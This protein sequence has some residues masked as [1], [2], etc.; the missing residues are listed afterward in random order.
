MNESTFQQMIT[1]YFDYDNT[2]NIYQL[3]PNISDANYF[4]RLPL[5]YKIYLRNPEQLSTF[6]EKLLGALPHISDPNILVYKGANVFTLI[7]FAT[8]HIIKI[9]KIITKMNNQKV[10]VNAYLKF[11]TG[12]QKYIQ[13]DCNQ[14]VLGFASPFTYILFISC[15]TSTQATTVYNE[16][17]QIIL[18][19]P[20]DKNRINVL[21]DV[22][23]PLLADV[24]TDIYNED[25][26]QVDGD[27]FVLLS[28]FMKMFSAKSSAHQLF[29]THSNG[30]IGIYEYINPILQTLK[31]ADPNDNKVFTKFDTICFLNKKTVPFLYADSNKWQDVLNVLWHF[32]EDSDDMQNIDDLLFHFD[33]PYFLYP[34]MFFQENKKEGILFPFIRNKYFDENAKYIKNVLDAVLNDNWDKFDRKSLVSDLLKSIIRKEDLIKMNK[35]KE[36]ILLTFLA[37]HL[38]DDSEEISIKSLSHKPVFDRSTNTYSFA[39]FQSHSLSSNSSLSSVLS[40]KRTVNVYKQNILNNLLKFVE[41]KINNE[42]GSNERKEYLKK[43]FKYRKGLLEIGIHLDNYWFDKKIL[44]SPPSIHSQRSIEK[45]LDVSIADDNIFKDF[46]DKRLMQKMTKI[47]IRTV[48]SDKTDKSNDGSRIMKIRKYIINKYKPKYDYNKDTHFYIIENVVLG[49]E[50]EILYRIYDKI[51]DN[52]NVKYKIYYI[53]QVAEDRGGPVNQFFSEIAKQIKD[54]YFERISNSDG[55]ISKRYILKR[56]ITAR[57]AKFVGS[58]LAI[59]IL[60]NVHIP[61]NLS[62]VYLGFLMF[63]YDTITNEELFLYYALDLYHSDRMHHLKGCTM[64]KEDLDEYCNMQKIAEETIDP[65]YNYK[66]KIFKSYLT[67]FFIDKKIFN[68]IYRSIGDKIRLYDMDKILSTIEQ[69]TADAYMKYIFKSLILSIDNEN[70]LKTDS[71][72]FVY[73]YLEEFFVNDTDVSFQQMFSDYEMMSRADAQQY[74]A[75]EAFCS[76]LLMFWTGVEGITADPPVYKVD[77]KSD[78]TEITAHTCSKELVMPLNSTIKTKQDLYNAFMN[79]FVFQQHLQFGLV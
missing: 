35:N 13:L 75:K 15:L 60:Y 33:V 9:S 55:Y 32:I 41:K 2:I 47:Y 30:S 37:Q 73:K 24:Y 65:I 17:I 29:Q 3:I 71:R 5:F 77:L 27:R 38:Y 26:R 44:N 40:A 53:K 54:T 52:L 56:S 57:Q 42:K 36:D 8:Y 16:Y 79:I 28:Y 46:T 1:E 20:S 19:T 62:F 7:T 4:E 67:G 70:V 23:K 74:K 63:P 14:H 34:K 11:L 18:N 49:K 76:A 25:L 12:I 6:F 50:L 69:T 58:I 45:S 48:E 68:Y 10:Y 61:F 43:L 51:G 59:L 31:S 66:S 72:A 39:S 22:V 78:V 64:P 21:E